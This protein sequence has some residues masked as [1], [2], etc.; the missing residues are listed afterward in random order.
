MHQVRYLLLPDYFQLLDYYDHVNLL[1][2][3]KEKKKTPV[4]HRAVPEGPLNH[5]VIDYIG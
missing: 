5:L 1:N 3:R 4:G 2:V